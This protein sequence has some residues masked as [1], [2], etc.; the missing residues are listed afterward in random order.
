MK[1]TTLILFLTLCAATS[2]FSQIAGDLLLGG[3]ADLVK[4]DNDGFLGKAQ[5]GVEANYLFSRQFTGTAGIDIWTDEGASFVIGGRWYPAEVFFVRARGLIGE[6]DFSLGAGW[7]QPF[8]EQWRFEAIGDFYFS[9]EFAA[10]VGVAY[11]LRKK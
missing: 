4:T 5:L 1:R 7:H 9:G 2:T 6:N 10:R 3:Y 11:T 8:G